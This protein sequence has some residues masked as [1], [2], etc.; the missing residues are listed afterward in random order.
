V[1]FENSQQMPII[2]HNHWEL[3]FWIVRPRTNLPVG[4]PVTRS[5]LAGL[6]F[7]KFSLCCG[8]P[9]YQC[10]VECEV[11]ILYN[12]YLQQNVQKTIQENKNMNK[13][14][15]TAKSTARDC[16]RHVKWSYTDTVQKAFNFKKY[17]EYYRLNLF[18]VLWSNCKLFMLTLKVKRT[19]S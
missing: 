17:P 14:D 16:V 9:R 8:A 7:L 18:F 6:E 19:C 2:I 12:L 1:L 11:A 5:K 4:Q 10:T 3:H 15:Y 13:T